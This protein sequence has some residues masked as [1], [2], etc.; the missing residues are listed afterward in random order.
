MSAELRVN[1]Q[2]MEVIKWVSKD[3]VRQA[4]NAST[5]SEHPFRGEPLPVL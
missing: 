2:E 3:T 5:S 4:L 1:T